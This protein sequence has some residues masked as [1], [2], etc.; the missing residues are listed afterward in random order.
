MPISLPT[1]IVQ[2]NFAADAG[3]IEVAADVGHMAAIELKE[4]VRGA[5]IGA[6]KAEEPVGNDGSDAE[7][8]LGAGDG[9]AQRL[10][11]LRVGPER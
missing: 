4:E 8:L 11:R 9:P 1:L 3:L 7:L 6:T 5:A 10:R 2:G